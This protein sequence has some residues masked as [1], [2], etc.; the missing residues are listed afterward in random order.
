M[1]IN[2]KQMQQLRMDIIER[3]IRECGNP[4]IVKQALYEMLDLRTWLGSLANQLKLTG[5]ITKHNAIK[6]HEALDT[7]ILTES[8]KDVKERNE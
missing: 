2:E 4:E 8:Y 6:W 5:G 1:N 7:V 3:A